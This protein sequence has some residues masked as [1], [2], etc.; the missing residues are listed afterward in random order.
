MSFKPY[1][2]AQDQSLGCLAKVTS[3]SSP[4]KHA[5]SLLAKSDKRRTDSASLDSDFIIT[6]ETLS[7]CVAM[8]NGSAS[9]H[10]D[11]DCAFDQ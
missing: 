1:S 2:N 10:L 3:Q 8:V 4:R 6:P 11:K 7:F 9:Y 5:N